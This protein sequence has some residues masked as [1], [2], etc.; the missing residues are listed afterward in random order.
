LLAQALGGPDEVRRRREHRDRQQRRRTSTARPGAIAQEFSVRRC[1]FRRRTSSGHVHAAG[2]GQ[3]QWP[4]PGSLSAPRPGAYRRSPDQPDRRTPAVERGRS[5]GKAAGRSSLKSGPR[6]DGVRATLTG[7]TC[8]VAWERTN[9]QEAALETRQLDSSPREYRRT[10]FKNIS[11]PSQPRFI[12][13]L[14]PEVYLQ[15]TL[16]S[17][18][19]GQ[20]KL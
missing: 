19:I 2:N 5:D 12:R 20:H 3:A 14:R 16:E 8:Y 4:E 6:Q 18:L 1:R 17:A 13:I 10:A 15:E 9:I 11:A 7:V